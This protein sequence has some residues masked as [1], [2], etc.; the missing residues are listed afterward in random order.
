[1]RIILASASPRRKE[2]LEK[3]SVKYE[4]IVSDIEEKVEE[5]SDVQDFVKK[6]A[7]Q[8]AKEVQ[9]NTTGDRII[10]AA[11][12]IV[13]MNNKILGKPK[14]KEDAFNMLK[15]LQSDSCDVITGIYIVKIKNNIEERVYN[16]AKTCTVILDDM[17]DDEINE[18]IQTGEPM[19]KAGA[20]AIQGIGGKYIK[21]ITGDYYAIVG[22]PINT[23]YRILREIDE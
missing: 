15:T 22:L 14:D 8:K 18:Y 10:I 12:T 5:Y 7:M 1:M 4:V 20:F 17:S 16:I 19:D 11:D 9:K 23:V 13:S 6:L 3:L 21:E 2:L